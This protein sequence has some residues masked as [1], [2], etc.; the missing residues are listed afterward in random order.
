MVFGSHFASMTFKALFFFSHMF[1]FFEAN[2]GGWKKKASKAHRY[3]WNNFFLLKEPWWKEV[4]KMSW[5]KRKEKKCFRKKKKKLYNMKLNWDH[6]SS[7]WFEERRNLYFFLLIQLLKF[8][9]ISHVVGVKFL[10]RIRWCSSPS[11]PF[12]TFYYNNITRLSSNASSPRMLPFLRL[13]WL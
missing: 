1:E 6:E 7:L 10:I 11:F 13:Y 2:E 4:Q 5:E 9:V 8:F 12:K 3:V